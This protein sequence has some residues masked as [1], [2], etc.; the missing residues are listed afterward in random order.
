[1][2]TESKCIVNGKTQI[3]D[4][5]EFR[6]IIGSRCEELL[7]LTQ[8]LERQPLDTSLLTRPLLGIILSESAMT[9]ELLDAY[10]A[11]CN[12]RWHCFRQLV[13]TSKCF[14]EASYKL[15]HIHHSWRHY[16][17]L[18][19]DSDIGSDTEEAILFCSNV[20][21]QLACA[22]TITARK[23]GINLPDKK[24]DGEKL[25]EH[26]P[27]GR[28][29]DNRQTRKV[30][31]AEKTVA[32]LATAFLNLAAEAE[33]VHIHK[34]VKEID[35]ATCIPDPVNE[36]A[37]RQLEDKFHSLQSMYDTFVSDTDTE[38]L[39]PDLKVLR[40]HIS[41]IYHLMEVGTRLIHHYER[42]M[43]HSTTSEETDII[44]RPLVDP[45]S[46]IHILMNYCIKGSSLYLTAG[47]GL[48]Q[49]MLK[50]YAKIERM[51]LPVPRYRGFHVRPS[52]MVSKITHHY[53]S[54]VQM[55]LGG[56]IYDASAP[57]DLF[58]ANEA[59]NAKKRRMLAQEI[60]KLNL[61]LPGTL[62]SD[63]VNA[64]RQIITSLAAQGKLVIYERPIPLDKVKPDSGETLNQFAVD[65]ITR[66]L[67]IGKIDIESDVKVTFIG[68]RRVLNDIK[69]LA[70][71]GY[72]EDAFG[73]NIP[74]PQKLTY[75]RK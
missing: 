9:E 41:I 3:I 24:P 33:I 66:L 74:L 11:R 71:N 31:S 45:R 18:D 32:H 69:L 42:H 70:E 34:K 6:E 48:C 64:V 8:H 60:G 39:D 12:K 21:M 14:A 46:L 72:G 20:I 44:T 55:E 59:I 7:A 53:G 50:R 29:P 28:L 58:R 15:L 65:E 62:E 73:N 68:D 54:E 16:N 1:M 4:Q 40:G 43:M 13:A 37:I 67:A 17:L 47:K 30:D 38:L 5:S 63:M 36:E 23:L 61:H 25:A 22:F 19:V 49:A 52:T 2:A 51:T 35:Y 75:L 27:Q 26:L 56:E 57:L 10:G